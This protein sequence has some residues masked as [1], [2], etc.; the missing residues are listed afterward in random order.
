VMS[1]CSSDALWNASTR[2]SEADR[3]GSYLPDM[4]TMT[5]LPKAAGRKGSQWTSW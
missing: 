5:R 2:S 4:K 1:N 3:E